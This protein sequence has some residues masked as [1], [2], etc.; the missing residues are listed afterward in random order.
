ML[1][2]KSLIAIS[3]VQCYTGDPWHRNVQII[4]K[5]RN[6]TRLIARK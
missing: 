2:Y 5:L 3:G 4:K 6:A 1:S